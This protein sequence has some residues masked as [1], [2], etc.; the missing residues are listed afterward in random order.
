MKFSEEVTM[1]LSKAKSK[2]N[3][4]INAFNDQ[5]GLAASYK[6]TRDIE[7]VYHKLRERVDRRLAEDIES[8][9]IPMEIRDEVMQGYRSFIINKDNILSNYEHLCSVADD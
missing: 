3:G 5:K 8:D 7:N 1:Q 6:L 4:Q 2:L 9:N